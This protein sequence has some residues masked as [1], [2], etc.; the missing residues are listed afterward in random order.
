[1]RG[2]K[3]FDSAVWCLAV[4]AVVQAVAIIEKCEVPAIDLNCY[5]AVIDFTR[6][7]ITDSRHGACVDRDVLQYLVDLVVFKLFFVRVKASSV[8]GREGSRERWLSLA[9]PSNDERGSTTN[10][11]H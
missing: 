3:R 8:G 4:L 11:Y 10:N 5:Y 9:T 1:M 6:W 7:L 2:F